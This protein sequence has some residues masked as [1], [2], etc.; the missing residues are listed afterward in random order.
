MPKQASGE[1]C[2]LAGP[3]LE[4]EGLAERATGTSHMKG[5]LTTNAPK[6]SRACCSESLSQPVQSTVREARVAGGE[7]RRGLMLELS[8]ALSAL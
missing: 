8:R 4:G 1:L 6:Q 2:C 5:S 7:I 3:W